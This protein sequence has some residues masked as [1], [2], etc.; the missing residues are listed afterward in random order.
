MSDI[1]DKTAGI[2]LT[3]AD[4]A[5]TRQQSLIG[6]LPPTAREIAHIWGGQSAGVADRLRSSE[7]GIGRPSRMSRTAARLRWVSAFAMTAICE[8]TPGTA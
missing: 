5:V 2:L 6:R 7:P 4:N 1:G 3:E 8:D